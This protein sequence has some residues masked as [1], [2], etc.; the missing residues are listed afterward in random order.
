MGI[1]G[2]VADRHVA[3]EGGVTETTRY[4]GH[5]GLGT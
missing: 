4:K 5:R 2:D 3:S 1:I